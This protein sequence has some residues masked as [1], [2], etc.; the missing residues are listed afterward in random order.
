MKL[1]LF[2]R[3]A[4]LGIVKNRRLYV[5]YILTC[6]GMVMM[7]FIIQSLSYSPS[8]DAIPHT[9]DI[10]TVLGLGKFVVAVFALLFL[11]YTN[12]FLIRRRKKE[13]GLYN[14]LGMD[15]GGI[16][17]VL[18]WESLFSAV[19]S[20]AAGVLFGIAL[21]KL[22]E[23]GLMN[24]IHG[25][26]DSKFHVSGKAVG[27]TFGLYGAIFL[28]LLLR[29]VFDVA[30]FR[31]AELLKSEN[32]GEKPPKANWLLA[33]LGAGILAAAYYLAVT[34]KS[35]LTA[36]VLFFVAVIMVILATYLLFIAGSVTFCRLLQKNKRYYYKKNH[37]VSVSSMVYRMRR[38]GAGLASICILSTMVLVMVSST[39]SLYF[40]MEDTI[41]ARF[42]RENEMLIHVDSLDKLMDGTPAL[43]KECYEEVFTAHG[44]TPANERENVYATIAGLQK[45]NAFSPDAA[46]EQFNA[47]QSYDNIRVLYFFTLEDYNEAM[48]TSLSLGEEEALIAEIRCTYDESTLSIGGVTLD[49]IGKTELLP[50]G[51]ANSEIL[52]AIEIIIPSYESIRTLSA[53]TYESSDEP[54]LE[55]CCYYGYD[56]PE[57]D[58]EET[59]AVFREGKEKVLTR[60]EFQFKDGSAAYSAGCL[61]AEKDDFFTTFGG[62]F[63]LGILLSIL[64]IF[65]A[66]MIIYYKQVSE[67]YEDQARFAIMQKVGM[68]HEDIKR[69]INAQ[70]LM[71]FFAPLAFA[72]L[73][74]SFAFPLIWKIL[75][76]FNMQNLGFVI[77]V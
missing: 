13:F 43:V 59:A 20:L 21:S 56:L 30:R 49:V 29:T 42:P 55:M 34:I 41:R 35:P 25:A 38:N 32:I 52:P 76:L 64:F 5:P 12:S 61:A 23:L 10:R 60:K 50:V 7:F 65:A 15:K 31:P 36:L 75:R 77:L 45:G 14:I 68:S 58:A 47:I 73:H 26:I 71:V 22:A 27:M 40:G 17:R 53:V 24:A 39:A 69:S 11:F 4:W 19:I 74:L 70:I 62:L 46:G 33:L 72:G 28:L 9:G 63:F 66:A 57:T 3:L 37:F 6:A 44:V 51:Q 8:L 16:C 48:G 1:T 18:F 67:G 54:M 2:P